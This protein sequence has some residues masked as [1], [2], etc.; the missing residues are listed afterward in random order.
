MPPPVYFPIGDPREVDSQCLPQLTK[1]QMTILV[2]KYTYEVYVAKLPP[3]LITTWDPIAVNTWMEMYMDRLMYQIEPLPNDFNTII[4]DHA[5]ANF[6][7]VEELVWTA[8]AV[9]TNGL[10]ILWVQ[11]EEC[12]N[13]SI[14]GDFGWRMPIPHNRQIRPVHLYLLPNTWFTNLN[15]L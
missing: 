1:L 8:I 13:S 4:I 11:I 14:N 5:I 2:I 6:W 10:P 3:R 7:T 12:F 15:D 9:H